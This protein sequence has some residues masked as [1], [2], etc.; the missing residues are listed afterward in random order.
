MCSSE[1][2]GTGN[3]AGNKADSPCSQQKLIITVT[4]KNSSSSGDMWNGEQG[5]GRGG[6]IM[7]NISHRVVGQ[8]PVIS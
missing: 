3:I 7:F 2:L 5:E 6:I 8:D 4:S 1:C